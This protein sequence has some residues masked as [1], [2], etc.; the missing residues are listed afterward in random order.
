MIVLLL[1]L[2]IAAP[3]WAVDSSVLTKLEATTAIENFDSTENPL[4]N[5]GSGGTNN[6]TTPINTGEGAIAT[7][8]VQ[9]FAPAVATDYTGFRVNTFGTS[10]AAMATVPAKNASDDGLV[11]IYIGLQ[12]AGLG[13]GSPDGFTGEVRIRTTGDEWRIQRL[14]AGTLTVVSSGTIQEI[15][16]GDKFAVVR[17]GSTIEL[18]WKTGSSWTMI[19]QYTSATQYTGGGKIGIHITDLGT[20]GNTMDD[21]KVMNLSAQK[22]IGCGSDRKII[23]D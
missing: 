3:A 21:L 9:A 4:V 22:C 18:W 11:G 16:A 8:G 5:G 20:N 1:L 10:V 2:L 14:D 6:W 7:D 17:S 23:G 15:S 13:S 19:V 12:G